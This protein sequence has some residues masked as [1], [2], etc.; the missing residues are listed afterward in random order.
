MSIRHLFLSKADPVRAA[1]SGVRHAVGNSLP[2]MPTRMEP[3]MSVKHLFKVNTQ[4]GVEAN[5]D[6]TPLQRP[7]SGKG[8]DGRCQA[9]EAQSSATA[10]ITI[11]TRQ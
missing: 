6:M 2:S 10:A 7:L 3:G 5:E 1:V 8:Q 11:P 4:V 9:W